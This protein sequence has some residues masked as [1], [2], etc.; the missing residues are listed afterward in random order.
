MKYDVELGSGAM[1]YILNSV[2]SGSNIQMFV[3]DTQTA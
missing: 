3:G 1:I 2:K